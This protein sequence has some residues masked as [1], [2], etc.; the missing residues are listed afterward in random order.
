MLPNGLFCGNNNSSR[1]NNIFRKN[2]FIYHSNNENYK[3]RLPGFENGDTIILQY[4]SNL[5]ILSFSK[6]NDNGKLDA[7]IKNLPKDLT[8]Y[9]FVGRT[10]GQ[11]CLSVL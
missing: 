10:V 3:T 4:D 1:E 8:F 6:E 2:K 9:W 11:I 5:S 7:C